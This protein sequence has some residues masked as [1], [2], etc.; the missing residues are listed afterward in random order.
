MSL[1]DG[2]IAYLT[3]GYFS[4]PQLDLLAPIT[5]ETGGYYVRFVF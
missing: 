1:A 5:N 2:Q 4:M 3:E